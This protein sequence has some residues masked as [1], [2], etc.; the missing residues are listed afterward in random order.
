MENKEK[1]Q[2]FSL[3]SKTIHPFSRT[4]L[5]ELMFMSLCVN[6]YIA[7]LFPHLKYKKVSMV[8]VK[9]FCILSIQILL[10]KTQLSVEWI[11]LW[12]KN[13]LS[14][15]ESLFFI[16]QKIKENNAVSVSFLILFVLK[17]FPCT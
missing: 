8:I 15:Y 9:V 4:D 3:W 10:P 2:D 17:L 5:I 13:R 11:G 12:D 7:Q 1:I 6:K 16:R 14:T